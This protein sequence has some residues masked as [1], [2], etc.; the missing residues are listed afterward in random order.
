VRQGSPRQKSKGCTKVCSGGGRPIAASLITSQA[1]GLEATN[2]IG[3]RRERLWIC[4]GRHLAA[5]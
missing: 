5:V 1:V 3:R 2:D 4:S